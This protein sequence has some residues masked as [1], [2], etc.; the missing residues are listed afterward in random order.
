M[1]TREDFHETR[2]GDAE[3]HLSRD[4][5]RLMPSVSLTAV[6]TDSRP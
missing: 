1:T 2:L 3:A 6:C 4:W 5:E